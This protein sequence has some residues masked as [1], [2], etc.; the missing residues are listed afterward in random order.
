MARDG[1]PT[2]CS[3]SVLLRC[4]RIAWGDP[5][6]RPHRASAAC[7]ADAQR[8]ASEGLV[9]VAVIGGLAGRFGGW[10]GEQAAAQGEVV[11]AAGAG[12]QTEMAPC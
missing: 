11:L 12:K 8:L 3:R 6:D 2:E 1:S 9:A 5:L 7:R 4:G 10:H